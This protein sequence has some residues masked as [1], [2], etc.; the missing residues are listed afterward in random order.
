MCH[1]RGPFFREQDEGTK[2]CFEI[3]RR[4]YT[5]AK[6]LYDKMGQGSTIVRGSSAVSSFH[7]FQDFSQYKFISPFN[8]SRELSSCSAALGFAFASG[9]TDGPGYFDFT[10]NGTDGPA[11]KNP[12]WNFARDLLHPPTKEQKEC[13][14]PKP[15]LLDVGEL[16]FPY[17]W[18]ANVV[19]IQVLRVGQVLIVVASGEVSTMAGR[20]WKDAIAREAMQAL[21]VSKP[22][23]LL[24]GP[25]NTY[26][27]YITTEEEYS[28]QR[29][30]GASTLHGPHTLAA[31]VNL[32]LTHLPALADT[33]S[34]PAVP[35]GP[36]PPIN[37][38]KSMSFITPVVLDTPPIQK[39][40]GD[41][42]G[43]PEPNKTFRPG[44]TV[45][46]DFV[47]ANPRNNF[48][49]EGTFAAVERQV[50]G[51]KWEVVRDDSD[52]NLVYRW[53]RKSPGLSSSK[54]TIEWTIED[55][56]YSIGAQKVKSG[57][58][59]MVYY[60]DAKGIDG[61]IRE[62]KGVGPSFDVEA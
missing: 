35:H 26:V 55:D 62:F 10:Q 44:D 29:Y 15:I 53:G 7:T 41:V 33:N 61:K 42:L 24:G 14:K 39:K 40:F 59:R 37:T 25:A 57:T 31:H 47:G 45:K 32:T 6:K 58:Y 49:L 30:E 52:W 56:F 18:T 2:S 36:N 60:G 50:S 19:D 11:T 20:R 16:K 8:Q 1:G 27:H 9:T 51:D 17:A 3:G 22:I 5:A 21:D 43:S 46:T 13:H 34:V 54:V 23:V 48:R 4:Q 28:R 12:L 38:D